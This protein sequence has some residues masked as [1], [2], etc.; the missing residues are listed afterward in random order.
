L[1]EF[2]I[3]N[4]G[5][6]PVVAFDG[7]FRGRAQLLEIRPEAAADGDFLVRLFALCS[8]LAP[9]VPPALLAQQAA[10]QHASHTARH[11][12]AMRRIISLGARPIGRIVIGWHPPDHSHGIDIAVLPGDRNSGAGLHLLRAWLAVADRWGMACKLDV[13]RGNPARHLY[14]RLG[15]VPIWTEAEPIVAMHRLPRAAVTTR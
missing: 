13:E 1:H 10:I 3:A 14:A 11:P 2:L 4:P 9:F 8:P 12:G 15:F 6:S 5:M 7:A